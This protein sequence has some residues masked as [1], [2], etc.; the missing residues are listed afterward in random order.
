MS[1]STR[2]VVL[3]SVPTEA[4]AVTIVAELRSHDID[5]QVSGRYTGGFR[6]AAPPMVQV[7]V[8]EKDAGRARELLGNRL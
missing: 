3:T 7:L 1:D 6:A 5:A 8:H 2:P 4:E